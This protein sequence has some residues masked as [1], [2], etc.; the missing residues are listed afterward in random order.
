MLFAWAGFAGGLL[1][2]GAGACLQELKRLKGQLDPLSSFDHLQD[3]FIT[4]EYKSLPAGAPTPW[5]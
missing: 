2:P 3:D 4:F 5:A 1:P